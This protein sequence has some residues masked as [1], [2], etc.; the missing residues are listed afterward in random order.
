MSSEAPFTLQGVPTPTE[1]PEELSG[2]IDGQKVR[3][4]SITFAHFEPLIGGVITVVGTNASTSFEVV[5]GLEKPKSQYPGQKRMPFNVLLR[6]PLSTN[7]EGHHFDLKHPDLGVIP[8]V[9]L[10]RTMAYPDQP[11]GAYY[12][13]VFN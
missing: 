2:T 4:D 6:G 5:E 11:P 13:V 3:R 7:L 1:L 9:A 8:Y 10:T 12:E